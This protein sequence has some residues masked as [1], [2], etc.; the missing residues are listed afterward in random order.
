MNFFYFCNLFFGIVLLTL[1]TIDWRMNAPKR[2]YL[3]SLVLGAANIIIYFLNVN[4]V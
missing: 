1:G 2:T 3:P 4:V